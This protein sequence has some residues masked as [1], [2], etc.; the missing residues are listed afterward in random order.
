MASS[1]RTN[2]PAFTLIELLVVISIIAL[3]VAI[4]LPA[5]GSARQAAVMTQCTANVRSIGQSLHMYMADQEQYFPYSIYL[6]N[7]T[8]GPWHY[9]DATL[10]RYM[11]GFG[12]AAEMWDSDMWVCPAMKGERPDRTTSWG[13]YAP[14]G[15]MMGYVAS[16]GNYYGSSYSPGM[17]DSRFN[18][19][20]LNAKESNVNT[21][22]SDTT[23]FLDGYRPF[24]WVPT[25][26]NELG[27]V[28]GS[29]H[30]TPHFRQGDLNYG[31]PYLD[32]IVQGGKTCVVN[33][34]GSGGAFGVDDYPPY[35]TAGLAG[36][37]VQR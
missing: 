1:C 27:R 6:E 11:G 25:S 7:L 5:L 12:S 35:Y 19:T 21:P 28:S 13:V 3:L 2:R 10:G 36:W 14:N 9:M 30:P 16:T 32:N 23:V 29:H 33:L 24:S 4:L 26:F 37:Q 15:A 20:H 34:D 22:P 17:I 31:P 8:S 18:G